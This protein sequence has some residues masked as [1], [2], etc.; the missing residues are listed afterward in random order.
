MPNC[1]ESSV[2]PMIVILHEKLSN[3]LKNQE[4]KEILRKGL[5]ALN[6]APA[7][8][9]ID[10]FLIY[11]SEL[12]RWNR[13]INLTGLKKDEDIV[14]K[15][16]IDSLLYLRVIPES[17]LTIAD[18]GSG[19]GFPGI[20][21]KIVRPDVKMYL[22]EVSTKKAAFLRHIIKKIGIQEIAVIE[23]KVEDIRVNIELP[24]VDI[25]VTRALFT[26]KEFIRKA[27]HI[28]K[29]GGK[30]ILNK[31]PKVFEELRLLDPNIKYRVSTLNLPLSA[32]KRYIIEVNL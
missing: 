17:E 31:G 25:A 2:P 10:A 18:V 14:V 11:L 1:S 30:L 32:I 16:F 26:V 8:E 6:I 24:T 22:V 4:I 13:A 3:L 21:I 5:L 29:K 23:K 12:K 15:H 27:S 20:P 7:N 28:V 9:F 19:A